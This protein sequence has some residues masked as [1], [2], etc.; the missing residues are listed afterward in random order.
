MTTDR[1]DL[2]REY[3]GGMAQPAAEQAGYQP[4]VTAEGTDLEYVPLAQEAPATPA[5]WDGASLTIMVRGSGARTVNIPTADIVGRQVWVIDAE[6]NAGSGTITIEVDGAGTIDG[7]ANLALSTN[8]AKALLI[9]ETV[10]ATTDW[11]RL[12]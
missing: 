8:G 7:A 9:A 6:R 1:I 10:G 2:G 3:F 11:L 4:R 5:T 12:V